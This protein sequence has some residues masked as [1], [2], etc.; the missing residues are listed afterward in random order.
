[1]VNVG[2]IVC[3]LESLQV[4][5]RQTN[6]CDSA[7]VRLFNGTRKQMRW[8]INIYLCL[9]IMS[10][11]SDLWT[12]GEPSYDTMPS[13]NDIMWTDHVHIIYRGPSTRSAEV[14]KQ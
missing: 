9:S 6:C 11:I 7:S 10:Q 14:E 2:R 13:P 8:K 4:L 1:M 3:L 12:S 5:W